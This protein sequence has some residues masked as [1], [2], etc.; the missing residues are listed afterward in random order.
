MK[1]DELANYQQQPSK[2]EMLRFWK[3][4]MEIS[5]EHD[6]NTYRFSRLIESVAYNVHPK[7]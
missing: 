7:K 1:N 3:N 6:S 4:I 2:K 5:F